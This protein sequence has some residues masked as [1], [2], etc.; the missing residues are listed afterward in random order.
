MT[1]LHNDRNWMA[2]GI[3]PPDSKTIGHYMGEAGYKS[4]IA[5]K[6]Q[7]QSYDPP[8]YPGAEFRRGTGMHPK[9]AGFDRSSLFHALHTED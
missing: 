9:D 4:C 5:G 1:G 3:L 6:W 2:F 7:L 8:D